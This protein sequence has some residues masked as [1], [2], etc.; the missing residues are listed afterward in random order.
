[1]VGWSH[2]EGCMYQCLWREP[3]TFQAPHGCS[4]G[5]ATEREGGGITKRIMDVCVLGV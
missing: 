1:M 4:H 3:G 2:G 5:V